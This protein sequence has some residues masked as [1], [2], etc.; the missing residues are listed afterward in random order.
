MG[1]GEPG[2]NCWGQGVRPSVILVLRECIGNA[3]AVSLVFP[4]FDDTGSLGFLPRRVVYHSGSI[5]GDCL[6]F[7]CWE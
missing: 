4:A 2:F 7:H 6:P 1:W 3:P 5:L